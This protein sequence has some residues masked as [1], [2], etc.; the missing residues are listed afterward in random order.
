MFRSKR[1]GNFSNSKRKRE[2]H[3]V[4]AK[5]LLTETT[6]KL[7]RGETSTVSKPRKLFGWFKSNFAFGV[8]NLLSLFFLNCSNFHFPYSLRS[9]RFRRAFCRFPRPFA[10]R[11]RENWG[12]P[13]TFARSKSE[14]CFKPEESPAKTL[15]TQATSHKTK[16]KR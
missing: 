10:F 6:L 1:S 14:E 7:E 9:K 8:L 3:T 2:V 12:E 16:E 5:L 11:R 15:A 4:N 13:N